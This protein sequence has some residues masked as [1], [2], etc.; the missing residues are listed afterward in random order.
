MMMEKDART[1]T[2]LAGTICVQV[3]CMRQMV[4]ESVMAGAY[5]SK[6]ISECF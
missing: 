4:I 5:S 1:E 3:H 6:L 2:K